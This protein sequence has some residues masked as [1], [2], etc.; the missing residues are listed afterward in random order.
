MTRPTFE[1]LVLPSTGNGR[2]YWESV[3]A[4]N[5]TQAKRLISS[6]IPDDWKVGN[7]VRRK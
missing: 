3:E 2:S 4:Q 5:P 7:N 1:V 6:R